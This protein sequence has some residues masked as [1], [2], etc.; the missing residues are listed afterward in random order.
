MLIE[1]A[2]FSSFSCRRRLLRAG[3]VGQREVRAQADALRLQ[4]LARGL[5]VQLA[6]RLGPFLAWL[7]HAADAERVKLDVRFDQHHAAADRKWLAGRVFGRPDLGGNATGQ[8]AAGEQGQRQHQQ[9]A[10]APA[11]SRGVSVTGPLC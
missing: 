9:G 2:W 11:A 10:Q 4:Q 8:Q 6:R 5:R 1:T 3:L 7:L